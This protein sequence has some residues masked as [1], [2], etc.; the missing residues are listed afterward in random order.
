[1]GTNHFAVPGP[2][3]DRGFGG[4]CLPKDTK[5]LSQSYDMPL[6]DLVLELN[7]KYRKVKDF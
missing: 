3:G 4:P 1:M 7:D 5:A 6:L 2:V